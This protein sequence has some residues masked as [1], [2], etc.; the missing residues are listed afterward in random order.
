MNNNCNPCRMY[1]SSDTNYNASKPTQGGM[2]RF[3]H[4]L[5]KRGNLN[6]VIVFHKI[7]RF[8]KTR[9]FSH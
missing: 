9:I 6:G 3:S 2:S 8:S 5:Q 4:K 1:H 7:N